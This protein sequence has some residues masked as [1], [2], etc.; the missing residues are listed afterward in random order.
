MKAVDNAGLP[1]QN[2]LMLSSDG[3]NVNKKVLRLVNEAVKVCRSGKSLIDIG[4]CNIHIMHNAF[5]KGLQAH[6]QIIS[7]VI[8]TIYY[9]FDGWPTRNEQYETVQKQM[10]VPLHAFIKH[11]PSRW[12]TLL[13]VAER[14]IEQWST[15]T[16]Y[17][18]HVIPKKYSQLQTA[19]CYKEIK[20]M[21]VE[22]TT[23][24]TFLFCDF[25]C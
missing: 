3:P 6:G 25:V 8:I 2:M 12:L 5:M 22:R 21:L 20:S 16:E 18:L 1:L 4:T 24:A 7:D 15:V 14:I 11:V 9:F 13:P 23:K 10:G 17:F 19:S